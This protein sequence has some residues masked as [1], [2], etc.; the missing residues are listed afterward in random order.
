[1]A[2]RHSEASIAVR[3]MPHRSFRAPLSRSAKLAATATRAWAAPRLAMMDGG[4]VVLTGWQSPLGEM[5]RAIAHHATSGRVDAFETLVGSI[6][7]TLTGYRQTLQQQMQRGQVASQR[8]TLIAMDDVGRMASGSYLHHQLGRLAQRARMNDRSVDGVRSLIFDASAIY[9]GFRNFLQ[10]D[11]L[12]N[13]EAGNAPNIERYE[14]A[15]ELHVGGPVDLAEVNDRL[16]SDFYGHCS[17]IGKLCRDELG[18]LLG[19]PGNE[20][21]VLDA[22]KRDPRYLVEGTHNFRSALSAMV[23]EIE[24]AMAPIFGIARDGIDIGVHVIEGEPAGRF[25]EAHAL[26]AAVGDQKSWQTWAEFVTCVHEVRHAFEEHVK[27]NSPGHWIQ[28]H[29][30]HNGMG[31]GGAVLTERMLETLGLLGTGSGA[32]SSLQRAVRLLDMRLLQLHHTACGLVDLG[33][34]CGFPRRDIE[35]IRPWTENGAARFLRDFGTPDMDTACSMVRRA[36]ED[37][38]QLLSYTEGARLHEAAFAAACGN[39]PQDGPSFGRYAGLTDRLGPIPPGEIGNFLEP[40]GL[41]VG[42]SRVV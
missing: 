9:E 5:R 21:A 4:D 2:S 42:V 15:Y 31:E 39:K 25:Y 12:P 36:F 29:G 33:L 13:A 17:A 20:P 41:E 7:T 40:L 28:R 1:M 22:L 3:L 35:P 32:S 16:W 38:A 23:G 30:F 27:Q 8:V 24:D 19:V 18:P 37:R 26:N 6:G 14:R 10:R 34:N 11:Y